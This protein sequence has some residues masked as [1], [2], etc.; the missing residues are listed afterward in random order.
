MHLKVINSSLDRQDIKIEA[1]QI[2][3]TF[4]IKVIQFGKI[5]LPECNDFSK[6]FDKGFIKLT[7]GG[8]NP[9]PYVAITE[10]YDGST[11]TEVADLNTARN[12]LGAAGTQTAAIA[13]GGNTGSDVANVELWDG[14]SWTETTDINTAR[15]FSSPS[16][17]MGSSTAA[18]VVSG[19]PNNVES[20]DGT[21]WTA[22]GNYGTS[23][24][25]NMFGGGTQTA[26][27]LLT[28]IRDAWSQIGPQSVASE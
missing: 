20:W 10:S 7:F 24:V 21:S 5:F 26:I 9:G 13:A 1:V 6:L 19:D 27:Q 16:A 15:V 14:S 2:S 18:I 17:G 28:E 11:F 3:D 4:F 12:Y 22:S 8:G 23:S 25:V